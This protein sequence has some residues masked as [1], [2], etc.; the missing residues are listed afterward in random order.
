MM[1]RLRMRWGRP[2]PNV[3]CLN[4]RRWRQWRRLARKLAR[5]EPREVILFADEADIDLNPR[6][7]FM[8][9]PRGQQI[10][11]STPGKNQKAYLAGALNIATGKIL[12]VRGARKNCTL[13]IRLL[14]H[15][16]Q[17]V[18]EATTVRQK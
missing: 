18:G 11:I 13:F 4:P 3:R 9:M 7:G 1:K 16:A 14:P 6:S 15:V 10:E 12:A 2:R 5:V 17:A 8:W